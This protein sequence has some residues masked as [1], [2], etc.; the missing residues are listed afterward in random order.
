M[1]TRTPLCHFAEGENQEYVRVLIPKS[2]KILEKRQIEEMGQELFRLIDRLGAKAIVIDFCATE[3]IGASFLDILTSADK[4][5]Q[6]RLALA[7][8]DCKLHDVF[9][10]TRLDSRFKIFTPSEGLPAA[11]LALS[12]TSAEK[13]SP[14]R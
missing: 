8:V 12:S 2:T 9:R 1:P 6:G 14:S 13:H 3:Y 7:N 4:K 11:I 10:A 5:L